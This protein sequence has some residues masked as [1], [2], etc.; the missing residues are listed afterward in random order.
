LTPDGKYSHFE[1]IKQNQGPHHGSSSE[2][3][4]D[5]LSLEFTFN[6]ANYDKRG[7]KNMMQGF[8]H[9]WFG[10]KPFTKAKV[11]AFFDDPSNFVNP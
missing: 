9:H 7:G 2:V 3:R 10:G 5:T 4:R 1:I 11:E 8:K 6:V